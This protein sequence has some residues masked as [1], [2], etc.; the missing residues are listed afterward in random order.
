VTWK[1][2]QVSPDAGRR[3]WSQKFKA[4]KKMVSRIKATLRQGGDGGDPN[5]WEYWDVG[6]CVG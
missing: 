6:G 5:R 2:E 1:V 3:R 4:K